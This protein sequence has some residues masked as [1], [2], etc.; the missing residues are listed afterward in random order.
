MVGSSSAL[1]DQSS[2][3]EQVFVASLADRRVLVCQNDIDM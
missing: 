2:H 1:I 3:I